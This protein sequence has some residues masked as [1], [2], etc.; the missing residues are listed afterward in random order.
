MPNISIEFYHRRVFNKRITGLK[1]NGEHHPKIYDLVLPFNKLFALYH[2]KDTFD[3]LAGTQ[4][5]CFYST[6]RI[7]P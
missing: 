2:L 4:A 5:A 7:S 1:D 3:C 6:P